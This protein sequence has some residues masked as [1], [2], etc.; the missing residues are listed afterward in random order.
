MIQLDFKT[1]WKNVMNNRKDFRTELLK[2]AVPV[3]LQS[4]LQS[5]FSVV[6]QVMTG[7]L[8][9]A[10]IA[11]I[12]LAAKF[13]S[14]Y[15]VLLSAVAAAAGIMMAQ[16]IG[17]KDDREAGRSFYFHLCL[18]LFSA[19][20]FTGLSSGFP[21]QVMGIYTKD[22]AAREISAEYLRILGISFLPM[23][24]SA[25][26]AV[27]LRCREAAVLPLY[28]G[29][30]SAALNT[31]LNYMLIFGK[32][33]FPVM[34]AEGAALATLLSR[35]FECLLSFLLFSGL[36]RKQSWRLPFLLGME[37][38]RGGLYA[39]ILLPIL[40]C[41]FFWSL[42]ENVY[43]VI[44]G[45]MGTESCAAMTL[46]API[47]VLMIGA[48]SG[49]AQ[50]A[51]I[52]VGKSLGRG[53]EEKA[54][55]DSRRLMACGLAGS[56]VL[57]VLLI[58]FSRFYV[59]IYYVENRVREITIQILYMFAVISPVKVQNMI[60]GGGIIRSGGRTHYVMVI[61]L[62]G[63]WLFGV[64]LGFLAAF[65]FRLPI[66]WVYF[67]LSLEECVRFIISFA[68]FRRRGWIHNLNKI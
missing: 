67:M 8:G 38:E 42:G 43:A 55:E 50:A 37:K 28:S 16:Y 62:I 52:I 35:T 25:M 61:D 27:L 30:L 20:L 13:A 36:K 33:G 15:S 45:H 44:Y 22:A 29:I 58:I 57:S 64:P 21:G 4:L 23:S 65:V 34:G 26:L 7:Q 14:L 19:L 24:V 41:E 18:A 48:L 31:I 10:S 12:G 68:V 53:E 66:A 5:S 6:D 63:T 1:G 60:L 32:M 56:L 54:Y 9:S 59:Q 46:T 3:T 49:I 47:Q 51:G 11:G 40:A 17:K 2:I 39:R